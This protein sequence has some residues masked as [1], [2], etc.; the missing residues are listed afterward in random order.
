MVI[1]SREEN[2]R[3]RARGPTPR[4]APNA[5]HSADKTAFGLFDNKE[6]EVI[7]FEASAYFLYPAFAHIFLGMGFQTT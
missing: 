1:E 3:E 2:T 5:K 7:A 6:K 4:T